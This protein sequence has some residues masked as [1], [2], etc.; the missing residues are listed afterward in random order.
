[1]AKQQLPTNFKDDVLGSQMGGKRRYRLI[2]NED[3]TISFEDV[4][5]YSQTGSDFG[6]AQMNA[7]NLAVNE[8]AD[9]NKIIDSI[10]DIMA[11]EQSGYI[12]GA[13][14][15]K[16]LNKVKVLS[17]DE[18]GVTIDTGHSHVRYGTATRPTAKDGTGNRYVRLWSDTEIATLLKVPK[19]DVHNLDLSIRN[20]DSTHNPV[21]F[22]APEY[23]S[24]GSFYA[25][26]WLGTDGNVR[27]DYRMECPTLEN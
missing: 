19:I 7:T 6:S 17:K 15:V 1:M 11:N 20:G 22:Y 13:L 5:E 8:S 14:A 23:W 3:G 16:E 24:D 4:T 12:A 9:K 27:V 2:N 18:F 26:T 25:Y 21:H 10:S